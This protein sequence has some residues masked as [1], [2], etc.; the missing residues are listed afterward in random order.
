M[1]LRLANFSPRATD[2]ELREVVHK[3]NYKKL[4]VARLT[5]GL[6]DNSRPGAVPEFDEG[7]RE[8]LG[9]AQRWLSGLYWMIRS[10][11]G[12]VPL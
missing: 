12:Y 4:E 9:E 2:E 8:A 7:S 6:G 3:H 11:T 1:K 10:G 5:R